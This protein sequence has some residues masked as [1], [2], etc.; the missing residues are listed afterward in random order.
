RNAIGYVAKFVSPHS[1]CHFRITE[2]LLLLIVLSPAISAGVWRPLF[3]GRNLDGWSIAGA[4]RQAAYTVEDGQIR[5]RPGR[6]LL[7]FSHEM[8]GD[9]TLRIIYRMTTPQGNSGVFIRIPS[10]PRDESFAANK[11]IEVQIDE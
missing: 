5:T 4:D 8:I 9:A 2:M 10:P 3:N 11:G 1:L 6:G 7:W